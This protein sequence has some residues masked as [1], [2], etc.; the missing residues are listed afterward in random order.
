MTRARRL[1][2]EAKRSNSR[3]A[4]A[5]L[6]WNN[7]KT[8]MG[9]LAQIKALFFALILRS[10]GAE[11]IFLNQNLPIS[12]TSVLRDFNAYFLGTLSYRLFDSVHEP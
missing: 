2:E 7:G 9:N 8:E 6:V 5:V 10:P 11:G 4:G 3:R 12:S 1:S